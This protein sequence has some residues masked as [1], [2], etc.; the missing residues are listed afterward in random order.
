MFD[1]RTL[2][3]PGFWTDLSW[4]GL[5]VALLADMLITRW[6]V[7]NYGFVEKNPLI[8]NKYWDLTKNAGLSFL[9]GCLRLGLVC[10]LLAAS[11]HFG[12]DRWYL[13][14]LCSA[15]SLFGVVHN[16]ILIRRLKAAKK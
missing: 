14:V 3:D 6:G 13:P 11:D 10:G 2:P 5:W 12:V 15:G 7:W 16:L 8:R 1:P 4:V 9:D